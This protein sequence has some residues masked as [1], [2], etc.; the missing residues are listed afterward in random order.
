MPT[1]TVTHKLS[2]RIQGNQANQ[3]R[4]QSHGNTTETTNNR[5]VQEQELCKGLG[6]SLTRDELG[7]EGWTGSQEAC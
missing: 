6:S 5:Q 4:I 7:G 3:G 2:S 1:Y